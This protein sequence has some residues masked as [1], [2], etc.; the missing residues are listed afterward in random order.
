MLSYY[1]SLPFIY[2]LSVLPFKIIYLLSDCLYLGLYYVIGYR[3]KVVRENLKKSFP[4]KSEKE[5]KQIEKAYFH[6]LCDLLLESLK[7]YTISEKEL[8]KRCT[9]KNPD[10][11]EQFAAQGK[12]ICIAMGHY[13]NWEWAGQRVS[14]DTNFKLLVIYRKIKNKYFDR[15]MQRLRS[16]FGAIPVEMRETIK[17]LLEYHK[18][19][20]ATA[21]VFITDQTPPPENAYWIYFLNQITP[22]FKGTEKI[23]SKYNLPVVFGQVNKIKRGFYEIELSVLCDNPSR[24]SE[25]ELTRLHTQKLESYIQQKPEYWLWSHR[26]WKHQ[27]PFTELHS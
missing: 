5:I 1:I 15:F 22:V 8:R 18:K 14:M 2:L 17:V 23:A 10:V 20:Y 11:M 6:H 13:G 21:T 27:P 19:A 24:L 26:R 9:I 25:K 4:K 3:K 16:R 12:S 7:A